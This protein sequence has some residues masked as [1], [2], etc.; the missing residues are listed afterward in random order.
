MSC[1][2]VI[3]T[4]V[5]FTLLVLMVGCWGSYESQERD[6]LISSFVDNFGFKPPASVKE[7]KMKN[8]GVY[9]ATAHC[10]AFTY[11]PAVFSRI[12]AND[13]ALKT[14][15]HNSPA[16]SAITEEMKKNTNIPGWLQLPGKETEQVYYNE[17]FMDHTFSEYYLWTK[18]ESGMTFLFVHYFD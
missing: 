15:S 12:I 14:V 3:K 8:W 2:N 18:K 5:L 10:M 1:S 11:D 9:D 6:K 4:G 7:I 17:D 13:K 16:F